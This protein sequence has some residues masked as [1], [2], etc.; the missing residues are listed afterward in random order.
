[1]VAG[2]IVGWDLQNRQVVEALL[3]S[4]TY[5]TTNSSGNPMGGN[6]P[7]I[8]HDGRY[9][10]FLTTQNNIVPSDT[11][12]LND[13]YLKDTVT[14]TYTLVSKSSAGVVSDAASNYGPV[15]SGDGK[16]V[17]YS[18]AATNLVAND[19]NGFMDIFRYT[20]ATGVTERVNVDSN[21]VEANNDNS[22][23]D[24]SEDGRFVVFATKSNNLTT[25]SDTNNT[26]DVVVKDM[27]SG[28]AKYASQSNA[29]VIGSGGSSGPSI[30][31]DGRFITYGHSSGS[32]QLVDMLGT[33]TNTNITATADAW[34]TPGDISCDG[35]YIV[36]NSHATNLGV[37]PT[38]GTFTMDV[39]RYNRVTGVFDGVS[40]RQDGSA[41]TTGSNAVTISSDGRYVIFY[42]ATGFITP[43]TDAN[44]AGGGD[45]FLRDMQGTG[46]RIINQTPGG[47]N[48]NNGAT[49]AYFSGTNRIVYDSHASN[50]VTGVTD[51]AS[52]DV[53]MV[54]VGPP[55]TCTF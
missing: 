55:N 29:G 33:Q 50:L 8:S 7:S 35:K 51:P 39:F 12:N 45:L 22:M 4:N 52:M 14:N 11:N 53:F 17:V 54:D 25:V 28:V 20:V 40:T 16:Y 13:V 15:I 36:F 37:N 27:S 41:P 6:T 26:W 44:G 34:S 18:S 23:A 42:A 43:G 47:T 31:C 48:G 5:V 46:L 10:T 9:V 24:V 3:G 2:L 38:P 49:N 1:M 30:S 32:I 19:T 21:G